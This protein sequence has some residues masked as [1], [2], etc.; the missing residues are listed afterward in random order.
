MA[1]NTARPS[2]FRSALEE[3]LAADDVQ[4]DRLRAFA[5]RYTQERFRAALLATINAGR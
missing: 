1:V 4:R 3:L 5:A 2:E